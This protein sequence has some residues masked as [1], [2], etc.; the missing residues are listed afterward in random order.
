MFELLYR[1]A[2]TLGSQGK[3]FV[4]AS[5][6]GTKGSTPQKV[7]AKLLVRYDGSILGTLG[8][9]CVEAEA[10]QEAMA[11]MKAGDPVLRDFVLT[12][13]LAAESGLVCGGTMEIF[14]DPAWTRPEFPGVAKEILAALE[15]QGRVVLATRLPDPGAPRGTWFLIRESGSTEGSLGS[16]ELARL[17]SRTSG[18]VLESDRA[19]LLTLSSG[20]R[21]YLEPYQVPPTLFVV[22]CGHVGKAVGT[23]G[24][25]VGFRVVVVDDRAQFANREHF[26]DADEIL[27]GDMLE[28]LRAYPIHYNTYIVIATRGHKLDYQATR[29][30]ARSRARYV[31]L[32]GSKRKT[33][34]VYRQLFAD[35][36]SEEQIKGIR[37]PVGL[38]LG[39]RSP[40]EI[41]VSI[42]AEIL[43]LRLGG[44]GRMLKM[45]EA[46]IAKAKSQA[47]ELIPVDQGP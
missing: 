4:L 21:L 39:A 29:E 38:D 16:D 13:E 45:D 41:A 11:A 2:L 32:V 24:K 14:I 26:P 12:Q 8:G 3:P 7:G 23:L 36:L 22:G 46:L 30:A 19:A 10:W 37:A 47:A 31:G 33:I 1:E 20:V 42:I 6:V 25:F 34:L 35:G 28:T 44:S 17:A 9:G 40:E 27:V 15:G 5:V 18:K 43:A